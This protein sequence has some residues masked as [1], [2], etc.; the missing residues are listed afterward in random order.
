MSEANE[1]LE[2]L[3][4]DTPVMDEET[5]ARCIT[6]L[7]DRHINVPEDI[8]KIGVQHDHNIK[9]LVIACPRYWNG[10]DISGFTF[11]INYKLADNRIS[12]HLA[13]N[14]EIGTGELSEDVIYIRWV[15][16]RDVTAVKGNLTFLVCAKSVN[17]EGIEV[18]HWNSELNRDLYVSEGLECGEPIASEYYDIITQ[19]VNRIEDLENGVSGL[20]A[21]TTEDNG[22]F[23]RVVDGTWAADALTDVSEVAL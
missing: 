1:L 10:N 18:T 7:E 11:Y 17:E 21:V 5:I 16:T 4:A 14:V 15:I 3:S 13:D 12:C 22:K 2:T 8:R 23:M 19:L 6:V 20:P 9:T